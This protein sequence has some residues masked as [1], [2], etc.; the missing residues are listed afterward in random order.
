[1]KQHKV[2]FTIARGGGIK[3]EVIDGEGASCEEI[4]R[5]LEL[6]L[7]RVGEKVD[8]GRKPEYYQGNTLNTFSS[9]EF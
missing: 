3:M 6:H 2:K 4:T 1:M 9:I 5:D 8:S 7:S